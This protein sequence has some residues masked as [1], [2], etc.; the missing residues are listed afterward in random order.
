MRPCTSFQS[1]ANFDG[2][3]EALRHDQMVRDCQRKYL[4]TASLLINQLAGSY[5]ARWM[6]A[7]CQPLLLPAEHEGDSG[8]VS[9]PVGF[10][11][12]TGD[13]T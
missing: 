3:I 5:T 4:A 6:E 2:R 1:G 8:G 12:W 9:L 10:P 7:Q 13:V 11:C